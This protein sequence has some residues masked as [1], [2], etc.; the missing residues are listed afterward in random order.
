M[1]LI[2]VK[3]HSNPDLQV[4]RLDPGHIYNVGPGTLRLSLGQGVRDEEFDQ[5]LAGGDTITLEAP[6]LAKCASEEDRAV[7][8]HR[9]LH[10]GPFKP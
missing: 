2:D 8:S 3:P 5:T 10:L 6:A 9:D 4:V 1:P 7:L